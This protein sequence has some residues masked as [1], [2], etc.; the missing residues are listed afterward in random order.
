MESLKAILPPAR[1]VFIN[2]LSAGKNWRL[3]RTGSINA[4]S[5]AKALP[6]VGLGMSLCHSLGSEMLN[7]IEPKFL[8]SFSESTDYGAS[9]IE[10]PK[11]PGR[12]AQIMDTPITYSKGTKLNA[13]EE[14]LK[15]IAENVCRLTLPYANTDTIDVFINLNNT[16][17]LM[18]IYTKEAAEIDM[19]LKND[20]QKNRPVEMAPRFIG[21]GCFTTE[22]LEAISGQRR[23][24]NYL[25]RFYFK[26][27]G[28]T[29]SVLSHEVLSAEQLYYDLVSNGLLATSYPSV[30]K[31]GKKG[32]GNIGSVTF[33]VVQKNYQSAAPLPSRTEVVKRQSRGRRE[34]R[35]LEGITS[36]LIFG[37]LL[38]EARRNKEASLI[39]RQNME[40]LRQMVSEV[41]SPVV[42]PYVNYADIMRRIE[43]IMVEL[44]KAMQAGEIPVMEDLD[45]IEES[46]KTLHLRYSNPIFHFYNLSEFWEYAKTLTE[47]RLIHE[48]LMPVFTA[49]GFQDLCN[50]HVMHPRLEKADITGKIDRRQL[51]KLFGTEKPRSER[52]RARRDIVEYLFRDLN[53]R[54]NMTTVGFVVKRAKVHEVKEDKEGNQNVYQVYG[55]MVAAFAEAVEL[56]TLFQN[57]ADQIE[58]KYCTPNEK[59]RKYIDG[60]TSDA[61]KAVFQAMRAKLFFDR[62]MYV[63]PYDVREEDAEL[64][65]KAIEKYMSL[66]VRKDSDKTDEKS[67][68]HILEG[69][70]HLVFRLDRP[71][72][73][74]SDFGA[75]LVD[76]FR[77]RN[78]MRWFMLD[79]KEGPIY[80]MPG[81]GIISGEQMKIIT[82]D[83]APEAD[84]QDQ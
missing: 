70:F 30:L 58:A 75:T 37:K 63:T 69:I 22:M 78:W 51:K 83:Q 60:M 7:R 56:T 72:K 74:T 79:G 27:S 28:T 42:I 29:P 76:G 1:P 13:S 40:D 41:K 84:S 73:E 34:L 39:I 38:A 59:A 2:P 12:F 16:Y 68:L 81:T 54:R 45:K 21:A 26:D 17:Q 48:V 20:L 52:D 82:L 71:S 57:L 5:L 55:A 44:K 61:R 31:K 32:E 47:T 23:D 33:Y 46:L 49:M 10:L 50:Q 4:E 8:K 80:F 62:V 11:F 66:E 3:S 19:F 15:S 35:K 64:L 65:Q 9:V 25:H 36:S 6:H 43:Y 53:L 18:R 67:L 24:G 14:T 77:L